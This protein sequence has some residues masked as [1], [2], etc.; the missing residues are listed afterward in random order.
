MK[1]AFLTTIFTSLNLLAFSGAATISLNMTDNGSADSTM[2]AADTAGAPGIAAANWNNINISG[3]AGSATGT[4][5]TL[6]YDSGASVT[7]ASLTWATDLTNH[8]LGHAVVTG[9]DRM[10]KGNMDVANSGTVT[11]TGLN[12]VGTYDVYVYFDGA[13]VGNWRVA[14]YSIGAVTDGGEDSEG[15]N[16]G[17]AGEENQNKVYQLPTAGGTGNGIWPIVGPNNDEGNYVKL[18]GITGT[19][20]TLTASGGANAG[21]VTPRAPINGIQIV[22]TIPEPSSV[23]LSLLGAML[24]FRRRR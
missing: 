3:T 20:F 16:W 21:N 12:F 15:A 22:G 13:N 19:S 23:L 6:I 1:K 7:G 5:S 10:W 8:R 24:I 2:G 18:S 11:L 4:V 14:N 17:V 9:D